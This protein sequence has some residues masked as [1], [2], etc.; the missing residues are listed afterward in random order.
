MSDEHKEGWLNVMQDEMKYLHENHTF[1]FVKLLKGD[2]RLA[3]ALATGS[4]FLNLKTEFGCR[5]IQT[6][7]ENDDEVINKKGVTKL[8]PAKNTEGVAL[9]ASRLIPFLPSVALKDRQLR[10]RFQPGYAAQVMAMRMHISLGAYTY[11]SEFGLQDFLRDPL[12][13]CT[14]FSHFRSDLSMLNPE[15]LEHTNQRIERNGKQ[16]NT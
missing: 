14:L 2:G 7:Y 8:Q 10:G 1:Q 13:P 5:G 16:L 12:I 11:A 4:G 9:M 15:I 6:S 3:A